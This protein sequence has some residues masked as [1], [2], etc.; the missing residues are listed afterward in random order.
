MCNA[1]KLGRKT[2]RFLFVAITLEKRIQDISYLIVLIK[3]LYILFV[4]NVS[5][6]TDIGFLRCDFQPC[7]L[8]FQSRYDRSTFKLLFHTLATD[9]TYGHLPFLIIEKINE[10]IVVKESSNRKCIQWFFF[11]S[12]EV[13]VQ[14]N[15]VRLLVFD[16]QFPMQNYLLC[17]LVQLMFRMS[18]FCYLWNR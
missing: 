16:S 4:F 12:F 18:L 11:F 1:S 6:Y 13:I 15:C 10:E 14:R 7:Y 3:M 8:K 17:F 9:W 2:H 5:C